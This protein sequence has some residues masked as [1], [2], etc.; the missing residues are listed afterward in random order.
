ML[1]ALTLAF[2]CEKSPSVA[3]QLPAP[4]PN[5]PLE[6]ISMDR[7]VELDGKIVM[8]SLVIAKPMSVY[9][10]KSMIGGPYHLDGIERRIS[11]DGERYD[12]KDGKRITVK[13]RLWVIDH[14]PAQ[15]GTVFIPAWR[16]MRVVEMRE[17]PVA[18]F[19]EPP[20]F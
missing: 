16:E 19:T 15:V 5:I 2:G 9:G 13:S 7:A 6:T 18:G 17:V 8:A 3:S 11:L 10:R 12:L 1:L 20:G 14:P 4:I